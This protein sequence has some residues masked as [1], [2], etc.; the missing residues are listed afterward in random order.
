M[1]TTLYLIR[2]GATKANLE[3]PYRLQGRN[4]NS[5]LDPVGVWQ[6]ERTRDLLADRR[7]GCF[8]SSPL[9]RAMQTASIIAASQMLPVTAIPDLTE[10]DVGRW[11][12]LSWDDIRRREPEELRQ[13][14]IDP[15]RHGYPG[16]ENFCQVAKRVT[17]VLEQV[18]TDHAGKSV[19]VVGHHIVN[20]VY[21]AGLLGLAPSEAK[22]VRLDN[23]GVSVVTRE[24]DET[25]VTTLN[26]AFHLLTGTKDV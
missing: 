17:P 14:E 25:R 3:R 10:C 15:G 24:N 6:A 13:F 2:H 20:R 11:E 16:G 4:T 21:L 22:R 1:T 23:C 7:I 5:P 26:A 19:L 12:H 18:L 8:F 9:D